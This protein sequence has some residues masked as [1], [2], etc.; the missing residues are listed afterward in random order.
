MW[1]G[2]PFGTKNI[3]G[4]NVHKII[5]SNLM[6][7]FPGSAA[8][9]R[10]PGGG[11]FGT[12]GRADFVYLNEIYEI[13]PVTQA[14]NPDAKKQLEKYVEHMGRGYKKGTSKLLE[15]GTIKLEDQ[16]IF[17]I[18]GCGE[19]RAD[20]NLYTYPGNPDQEGI[21]YYSLSN[22]KD[23]LD[24]KKLKAIGAVTGLVTAAVVVISVAS[25]G[26]ATYTATE[27]GKEIIKESAA[28]IIF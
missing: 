11:R 21:I 22:K 8:E 26:G 27:I 28:A 3:V 4:S 17:S 6:I 12:D 16:V 7:R 10:I 23:N 19:I 18:P 5:E 15:I 24:Y 25:G 14:N 2:I 20:I 13:K 1:N 9:V